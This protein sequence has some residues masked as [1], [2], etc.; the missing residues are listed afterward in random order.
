MNETIIKCCCG[1]NTFMECRHYVISD[2]GISEG[3]IHYQCCDCGH[4]FSTHEF[5][6]LGNNHFKEH[7]NGT[8]IAGNTI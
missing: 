2:F 4:I 8:T 6:N 1:F 3:L 7:I 5:T